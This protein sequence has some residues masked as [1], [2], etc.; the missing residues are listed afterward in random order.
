MKKKILTLVAWLACITVAQGQIWTQIGPDIDGENAGDESG[1]SVSLS[2]DG[3]IVAIGAI[4]NDGIGSDAGHVRIYQNTGGTWTQIGQDIEG[5]AAG[6]K[7]GYS[8]SLNSD[9]S[10]VAIGAKHNEGN[11]FE[12]GHVRVYQNAAGTWTQIGQDIDGENALDQSGNAVKLS[13]DG[14]VVAIGAFFN[15]DSGSN[16]GHVRI[17]QDS[18]GTWTQIGQDIDGENSGDESGWSLSLSDDGSIVAIGAIYNDGNGSN[19]GHVRIYQNS[20]GIWTQIGSDIDGE[21][22]D[23]HFGYAVSLS[24]DGSILAIGATGNDGGGLDAGRVRIYENSAGTWTQI[25]QD[26]DGEADENKFGHSVSLSSDG[27]TVG[28]G[29]IFNYDNGIESGHVRIYQNSAGT[30]TQIGQDIDG[31]AMNDQSGNTVS[32]SSDGSTIAIGAH[33][34]DGN[35]NN[36]GHIKVYEQ[37]PSSL[38]GALPQKHISIYPNPT[39]GCIKFDLAGRNIQNLTIID[40]AGK[41]IIE[42][43]GVYQNEQID[44]SSFD[45][46]IYLIRILTEG[47]LL[48]IKLV[49]E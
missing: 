11:G 4:G 17:Y 18:A 32:L 8:L 39:S 35:G 42:K 21:A 40:I 27:S 19:S 15:D 38:N 6:D 47:E 37:T 10:I 9:G 30:W 44:L 49:K 46:G 7:S 31:E 43:S 12:N 48:T 26:I 33:F 1:T 34:N 22:A 14:S 5:E 2:A 29:S 25:G 23:D 20:A 45:N 13:G 24:A 41:Q 36:S 16:A 28:I 3:S